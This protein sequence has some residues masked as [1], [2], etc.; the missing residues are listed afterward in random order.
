M[1]ETETVLSFYAAVDG[2]LASA[3]S[4]SL[5]FIVMAGKCTFFAIGKFMPGANQTYRIEY[6]V[7]EVREELRRAS[8]LTRLQAWVIIGSRTPGAKIMY[9]T[10]KMCKSTLL[11]KS[12]PFQKST[13]FP[14]TPG[15]LSQ[16]SSLSQHAPIIRFA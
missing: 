5:K 9:I 14:T 11:P 3:I 13:L 12:T 8:C 16:H 7:D 1:N 6:F 4:H 15:S 10:N 2:Q